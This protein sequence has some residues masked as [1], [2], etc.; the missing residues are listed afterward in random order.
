MLY[1]RDENNTESDAVKGGRGSG[2]NAGSPPMTYKLPPFA[3]PVDPGI[4]KSTSPH[5]AL[6][7]ISWSEVAEIA[8]CGNSPHLLAPSPT[9]KA[10]SEALEQLGR[11]ATPK[12]LHLCC[13]IFP[14]PPK[15]SSNL[16]NKSF[17]AELHIPATLFPS[18][19]FHH[20]TQLSGKVRQLLPLSP[21]NICCDEHTSN[22]PILTS[23][24]G[25]TIYSRI[26]LSKH[27]QHNCFDGKPLRVRSLTC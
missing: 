19:S 16:H 12:Q 18:H 23:T 8:G 3:L 15:F 6:N 17:L 13:E 14:T 4:Y 9:G 25:T 20:R 26:T 21:Q 27:T 5:L 1:S 7:L 22:N 10:T 2:R 24:M 11:Q